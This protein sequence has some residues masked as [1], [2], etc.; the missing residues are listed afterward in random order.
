MILFEF[1]VKICRQTA[2]TT[3]TA[4][5][6]PYFYKA[7]EPDFKELTTQELNKLYLE[8]QAIMAHVQMVLETKGQKM[9]KSPEINELATALSKAQGV[10]VPASKDSDNP[11][12]KS[13]YADLSSVWEVA[14]EPLYKNG[15]AIIQLP[16]AEGNIVTLTTMLVH[17]SGQFI[18]SNLT[19]IAKDA[20]PQCIG[21]CI[22]YLRR[23]AL[24]SIVGIASE[25]DDDANSATTIKGKND[26]IKPPVGGKSMKEFCKELWKEKFG[27]MDKFNAWLTDQGVESFDGLKELE[28]AVIFNKIKA[29][30]NA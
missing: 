21:S 4:K 27:D 9:E 20:S 25:I 3:K 12:F 30:K 19:M 24:S 17:S 15:L 22:T 18:S 13:K 28:Y 23:Y 10:I 8:A 5:D 16:S 29:K 11:F 1:T 6:V 2:N 7:E 14:R 26:E